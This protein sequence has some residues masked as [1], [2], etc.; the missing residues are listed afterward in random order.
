VR[1]L[2]LLIAVVLMLTQCQHDACI[3]NCSVRK[4]ASADEAKVCFMSCRQAN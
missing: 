1:H 3:D 2:P 4:F